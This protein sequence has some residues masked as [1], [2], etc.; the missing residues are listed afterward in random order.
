MRP[1]QSPG[2]LLFL[3]LSGCAVQPFKPGQ[4]AATA[5]PA[6]SSSAQR[7]AG[8]APALSSIPGAGT[9]ELQPGVDAPA[10]LGLPERRASVAP[11]TL[12]SASQ[13]LVNQAKAQRQRGDLPGAATSLERALRIEPNNPLLWIEMGRLRMDQGNPEQAEGMGRK[14]LA[15]AI[16]DDSTQS[17]AWNLIADSQQARGR[18]TQ[19]KQS[20]EIA[21]ALEPN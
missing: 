6:Q 13:S 20:R 11:A 8:E 10:P 7:V 21:K 4:D 3:A 15:M 1:L 9:G 14:A 17:A 12:G 18:N 5:P 2:L 16:G 19:A